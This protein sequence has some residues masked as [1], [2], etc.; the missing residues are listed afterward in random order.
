[1]K[2]L[3]VLAVIFGGQ[4]YIVDTG[5][6]REDCGSIIAVGIESLTMEEGL[7]SVPDDAAYECTPQLESTKPVHLS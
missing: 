5:L 6:S 4:H 2:S 7:V 1:M 3:F